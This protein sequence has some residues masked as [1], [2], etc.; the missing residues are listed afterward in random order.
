MILFRFL[1]SHSLEWKS[2]TKMSLPV[3][4]F[5][6]F[7]MVRSTLFHRFH[8]NCDTSSLTSIFQDTM[9]D[10]AL[11]CMIT[12]SSES[13]MDIAIIISIQIYPVGVI[14]PATFLP[15]RYFCRFCELHVWFFGSNSPLRNPNTCHIF[16]KLWVQGCQISQSQ[17]PM[18]CQMPINSA[19]TQLMFIYSNL[20]WYAMYI[21]HG[22]FKLKVFEV[23]LALCKT[24]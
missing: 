6:C 3:I 8:W 18:M 17:I 11:K 21:I 16:E 13:R 23:Q 22:D 19:P 15:A 4:G 24:V 1:E 14:N 20:D 12:C 5:M 7:L 9:I 2:G 10:V